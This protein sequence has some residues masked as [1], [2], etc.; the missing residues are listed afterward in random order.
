[1]L[2]YSWTN[3]RSSEISQTH[4]S[5]LCQNPNLPYSHFFITHWWAKNP[6]TRNKSPNPYIHQKFFKRSEKKNGIKNNKDTG[7]PRKIDFAKATLSWVL[8]HSSC[9]RGSTI[10]VVRGRATINPDSTGFL[11]ASHAQN[12]MIVAE[13]TQFKN[14]IMVTL[15]SPKFSN[16]PIM[17]KFTHWCNAHSRHT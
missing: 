1:M 4:S 9:V 17:P 8:F 7:I 2:R 15:P 6:A 16:V 5:N 3:F 12:A 10:K 11:P 14:W 13:N